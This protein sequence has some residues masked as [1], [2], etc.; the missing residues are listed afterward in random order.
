MTN[1]MSCLILSR[2]ICS[3][4]ISVTFP[5]FVTFVFCISVIHSQEAPPCILFMDINNNDVS[6]NIKIEINDKKLTLDKFCKWLKV[7]NNVDVECKIFYKGDFY[8]VETSKVLRK[9]DTIVLTP[10]KQHFDEIT[11][12]S[13]PF[14][15]ESLDSMHVV[16]F[17]FVNGKLYTMEKSV[18]Q[19]NKKYV[20]YSNELY[21]VPR[22]TKFHYND[23]SSDLLLSIS[24]SIFTFSETGLSF[25]VRQMEWRKYFNGFRGNCGKNLVYNNHFFYGLIDEIV[26]YDREQK[27]EHAFYLTYDSTA[28]ALISQQYRRFVPSGRS[29]ATFLIYNHKSPRYGEKFLNTDRIKMSEPSLQTVSIFKT[30]SGNAGFIDMVTSYGFQSSCE[31]YVKDDTLFIFDFNRNEMSIFLNKE[32]TKR[33]TIDVEYSSYKN[34]FRVDESK[35]KAYFLVQNHQEKKLLEIDLINGY[36]QLLDLPIYFDHFY[37][38]DV[39]N[40]RL[41]FLLNNS[42]TPDWKRV[43]YSIKIGKKGKNGF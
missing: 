42:E 19:L 12:S 33:K 35:Q 41:Y 9:S 13:S 2:W 3:L 43:F 21:E 17:H 36:N 22:N 39:N 7:K 31:S 27:E 30:L 1:S 6:R 16:D 26:Y 34:I 15:K 5:V 29:P 37:H 11:V 8:T 28:F 25:F 38:W 24:D 14:K 32:M 18:N 40:D 4:P 23:F 10:K 20:R